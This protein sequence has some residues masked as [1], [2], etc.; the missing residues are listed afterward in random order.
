[1]SVKKGDIVKLTLDNI[2][3]GG[4][5]VG[6]VNGLAVFVPDGIP[7]EKVEVKIIHRKKNYARGEIINLIEPVEERIDP[8]CAVYGA[9]GG[10]QLQHMSY[11]EQLNNKKAIVKDALERIGKLQ[12]VE[13]ND[14]IGSDYPF[15]YRNKAQFPLKEDEEGQIVTGFYR[16]ATHDIVAHNNC[17]IQHPVINKVAEAALDI[18]NQHQ[19][20][21]Y[22]EEKHRGLLR[23]LVIRVG[24]CTNQALLTIVTKDCRFDHKHEIATEIINKVPELVGILHN[25]NKKKTNVIMGNKTEVLAG[26]DYYLDYIGMIKFAI[27][28]RSF[29][30][31]NT[32]QTK[33]LYDIILKYAGLRGKET[34]I[35]AY[36]GIGTIS[37]YLSKKAEKVIGIETVAEAV[38]DAGKNAGLNNINNCR[39]YAGKVEKMFPQLIK[40]G[41]IPDLL[42]F[43]PPRKGLDKKVIET[44]IEAKVDKIVYVSCNPATLARDI[45]YFK[46]LYRVEKIQPVNMFPQTYH[47]E[48]VVSLGIKD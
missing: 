37:L 14:V 9:C 26:K 41:I 43:D 34:V 45:S 38:A 15:N 5:C 10:C 16:K 39:F 21:V 6:R 17:D 18:L 48:T 2:T 3:N 31:V 22:N 8:K 29:F 33:K 47:V 25:I 23:H 13:V 11:K 20:T 1:M 42:V 12:K 32:L 4:D 27:S 35:D 40:E 46:K 24:I 28:N 30:Q 7:G 36:C 44:V 19:L